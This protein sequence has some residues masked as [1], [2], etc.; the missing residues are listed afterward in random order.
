MRFAVIMLLKTFLRQTG[1]IPAPLQ[2]RFCDGRNGQEEHS[3]EMDCNVP[4][5]GLREWRGFE[6]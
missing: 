4:R 2:E 5:Y 6:R 1:P 3:T